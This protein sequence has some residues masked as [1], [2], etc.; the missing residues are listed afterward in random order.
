[1]CQSSLI[2][3]IVVEPFDDKPHIGPHGDARVEVTK[4][5]SIH[6]LG[7]MNVHTKL[8]TIHIMAE[9]LYFSLSQDYRLFLQ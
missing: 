9:L 1:M 4:F 2:Y 8:N 5:C 6:C 7:T 3:P